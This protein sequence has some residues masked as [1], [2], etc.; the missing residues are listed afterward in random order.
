MRKSPVRSLAASVLLA[1]LVALST[2]LD[3]PGLAFAQGGSEGNVP[4]AGTPG[5]TIHVVQRGE[6]LF[7]IAIRYGTTVEVIARANG[8]SNVAS[9]SVGQRLLVPNASPSAPGV[10]TD[11]RVAPGDTLFSLAARFGTSTTVIARQN[12]VINPSLLYIG[13][14]LVLQEGSSGSPGVQGGWIHIVHP[15]ETLFGIAARYG[16]TPETLKRLNGLKRLTA[17]FPGQRLII[18]P[19]SATPPGALLDLPEPF[20][21]LDMLPAVAEQG[22][23]ISFR[24]TTTIPARLEGTFMGRQLVVISNEPR[25]GHVIIHGFDSLILPGV[26]PLLL[27]AT[28]DSGKHYGFA[29]NMEL[30]P[31]GFTS[32]AIKLAPSLEDLLN[33]TVTEPE[34]R[35]VLQVISKF[36]PT[37]R[38]NGQMGLPCPAPVTSQFGTRR[39]Y[40]GGPFTNV[41]AGTDFAALPGAAIYAPAAGVVVLA[42]SL[43]VRGN[44]TII[45]HG[46]GVYTGYWHQETIAVR[47]GDAVQ[48]GQI[49]GTVGRTGRVTGPHLHWELFIGGVQVDPLQ[50]VRQSFP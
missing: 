17:I 29:R 39:S 42:E 13:Q 25:T 47:V 21:A 24:M 16:A 44:A 40:N 45:D 27:T 26:Y 34:A 1:A 10:P 7:R 23:T 49:I 11:Y 14:S 37:R 3:A 2:V 46:W 19:T 30:A 35:K 18:P 20:A 31:G 50:W 38:F 15:N 28:D 5:M 33:P 48:Q 32:E 9:I 43:N 36:T 8:I 6:N 22:R 41:H 12:A 4:P